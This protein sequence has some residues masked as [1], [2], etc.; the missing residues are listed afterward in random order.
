[1]VQEHFRNIFFRRRSQTSKTILIQNPVKASHDSTMNLNGLL[2]VEQATT[3][4]YA[5]VAGV[6][7]S[8]DAVAVLHCQPLCFSKVIPYRNGPLQKYERDQWSFCIHTLTI[9]G[10]KKALETNVAGSVLS[11][12]LS[13]SLSFLR[14][15]SLS[16]SRALSL[17]LHL[18]ARPDLCLLTPSRYR[19]TK[20]NP[21]TQPSAF[22]FCNPS[23][24][25]PALSGHR[26]T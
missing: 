6:R 2:C 17:S 20:F 10:G 16:L 1:M 8:A 12:Y 14:C 11:I 21:S 25:R 7:A 9:S 24:Q 3:V 22:N 19:G 26:G 23:S 4:G 15:L 18:P 13:L 5:E